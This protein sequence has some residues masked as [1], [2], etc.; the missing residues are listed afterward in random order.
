MYPNIR[1][2]H[3]IGTLEIGGS[4]AF[5]MNIYR[6]IDR[7][8]MQFDFIVDSP[9]YAYYVPE[10]KSMGGKIYYFPKFNGKNYIE[11]K[12]FWKDFLDKH[13]EY[14]VFHS[15]VRSYAS[16]YLP[17]VKSYGIKTIIHS[18][19]NSNG[20][21]FKALCKNLLQL[22]LRFQADYYMACSKEAGKWLFGKKVCMSKK[23]FVINNAIDANEFVFNYEKRKKI[24]EELGINTEFVLGFLARVTEQKN[25]LFVID[26]MVEVLKVISDA[27]LLFVGDG[28][29]LSKVK[30]KGIEKG[31]QKN[32]IFTGAR[33][34]VSDLL[35]SMDCYILPS[36]W[37]G[38]GISLIEA[39]AS[40]LKCICSENIQDEAI[41]SKLVTRYSLENGPKKWAE[42]VCKLSESK[43]RPNMA[44]NIKKAGFDINENT[45]KLQKFYEKLYE[46]SNR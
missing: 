8:K 32:I 21:G 29:L 46:E 18:H 22:P 40:G 9:K 20:K 25:P 23:F 1:V 10:I 38:L 3:M 43:E 4:Q 35:S 36:L 11:I 7:N 28:E 26:V 33:T 2:L 24:R 37:E 14:K 15:H 27:K 16:I 5:I 42:C 17:I 19:N 31:I 30:K 45:I 13:K 34:D 41:I 6:K 39:Q 12:K 44:E